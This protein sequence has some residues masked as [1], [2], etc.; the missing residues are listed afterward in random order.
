[1][2]VN[3]Y[4]N[5]R[6]NKKE[7]S[8]LAYV[9]ELGKSQRIVFSTGQ[10][11]TLSS[12]DASKGKVKRNHPNS[13]SINDFLEKKKI[14]I[15]D[16]YNSLTTKG[17]R[18]DIY[19]FRNEVKVSLGKA[20]YEKKREVNCDD[21]FTEYKNSRMITHAPKTIEKYEVVYKHLKDFCEHSG[22]ELDL[23]SIGYNFMEKFNNYSIR[24]KKHSNNTVTKSIKVLKTFIGW[25]KDNGYKV[26]E[27]FRRFKANETDRDIFYLNA[28]E[29][30]QI[31]R[32]DLKGNESLEK[33]RDLFLFQCYT[34]QRF[35]DVQNMKFSD[36]RG[37]VWHLNVKKT[38]EN[39]TIP[40]IEPAMNIIEK[41]KSN[42][43]TLPRLSNQK[44]NN[45]LKRLCKIAKIDEHVKRVIQ[46]GNKQRIT[47]GPKYKFVGTHDARRSFIC[48]SLEMH[49]PTEVIMSVV[50][51]KSYKVFKKYQVITSRVK[52]N[53]LNR[54]WNKLFINEETK[55]DAD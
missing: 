36:I 38:K 31:R 5:K 37:G 28:E 21:I 40:I 11:A 49:I 54:T 10:K 44:M 20:A 26:N 2:Q 29:I 3:Y 23:E 34:G 7:H 52:E 13:Q 41:Y 35:S 51:Q 47:E 48:C 33:V 8:I 16:I 27:D 19:Q 46:S 45:Y 12:W 15:K 22:L 6:S 30:N 25:A 14:E 55:S 53:E 9:T 43:T 50:G 18:L 17:K 32:C 39:N 42:G 4:L 24:I 1:M